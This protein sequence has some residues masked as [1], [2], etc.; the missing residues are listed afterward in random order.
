MVLISAFCT[1]TLA[2]LQLEAVPRIL[3]SGGVSRG[4]V[5]S[6]VLFPAKNGS[7][8]PK[9]S[10][11]GNKVCPSTARVARTLHERPRIPLRRARLL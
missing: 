1:S 8:V 5:S 6:L 10:G 3:D 11:P 9:S 2:I 4:A 7:I